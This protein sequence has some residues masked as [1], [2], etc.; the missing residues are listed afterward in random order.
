MAFRW[1]RSKLWLET[2]KFVLYVAV[3]IALTVGVTLPFIRDT[4]EHAERLKAGLTLALV[5]ER[6]RINYPPSTFKED[7]GT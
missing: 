1:L 3:P 2:G 7:Q 4:G 5:L 6:Q